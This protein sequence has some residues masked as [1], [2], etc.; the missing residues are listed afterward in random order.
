MSGHPALEQGTRP[1]TKAGVLVKREIIALQLIRVPEQEFDEP[2]CYKHASYDFRLGSKYVLPGDQRKRKWSK[3]LKISECNENG[4]VT[5]PR[6]G[7][8]IIS[9]YEEVSLP[10]NVAGRF[11]LRIRH[12]LEGLIVQMGTQVEPG[13]NGPLFALIHNISEQDKTLKYRDYDTRPFTIEFSYTSEPS[14]PPAKK[15]GDIRDFIPPN[16]ARGGLNRVLDEVTALQTQFFNWRVL[17][18]SAVIMATLVGIVSALVPYFL[19][20]FTYDRYGF[21][22]SSI[23]TIV[24][25]LKQNEDAPSKPARSDQLEELIRRMVDSNN[26]VLQAATAALTAARAPRTDQVE[27]LVR[28]LIE[29]NNSA[30]QAASSAQAAASRRLSDTEI[31]ALHSVIRRLEADRRKVRGSSKD[32]TIIQTEIDRLRDLVGQ[33]R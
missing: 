21:P 2:A 12:A 28:K 29:S 1:P 32:A 14:S 8:A 15:R 30:I 23:E 5:I 18:F 6:F 13:Y 22:I 26:T 19:G 4:S 17:L 25:L 31:F 11:D 3:Q 27:E 7:S 16:Y 10:D 24:K 9:T 20:Q 33:R